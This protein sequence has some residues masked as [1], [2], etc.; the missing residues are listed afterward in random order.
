ML[1]G[2]RDSR[3][4]RAARCPSYPDVSGVRLIRARDSMKA[5]ALD[6]GVSSNFGFIE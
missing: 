5:A 3:D 4:Q 6:Q 1:Y 2:E